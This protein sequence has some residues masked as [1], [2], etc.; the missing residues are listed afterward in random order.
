MSSGQKCNGHNNNILHCFYL[1]IDLT[2]G[3]QKTGEVNLACSRLQHMA[4]NRTRPP[5]SQAHALGTTE[6]L[7]FSKCAE[8]LHNLNLMVEFLSE[9][10]DSNP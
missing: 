9:V 10:P 3:I 5:G 6:S 2:P 8:K 4:T 7:P 1:S